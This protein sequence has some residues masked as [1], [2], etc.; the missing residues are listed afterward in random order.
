[1]A[2]MVWYIVGGKFC[3]L[4]VTLLLDSKTPIWTQLSVFCHLLA[5]FEISE[6]YEIM[7]LAYYEICMIFQGPRNVVL[8]F[9]E[10]Q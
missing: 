2:A 4:G 10:M 8:E 5:C 9:S 3:Y 6:I 1:M 7:K